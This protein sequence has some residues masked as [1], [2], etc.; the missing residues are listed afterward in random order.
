MRVC[1]R[2][3]QR[4]WIRAAKTENFTL[5]RAP[6][7]CFTKTFWWKRARSL[8]ATVSYSRTFSRAALLRPTHRVKCR[9]PVSRQKDLDAHLFSPAVGHRNSLRNRI[10]RFRGGSV[11]RVRFSRGRRKKAA[12][13]STAAESRSNAR[14]NGP[15]S[16]RPD[17]TR[18]K[19]LSRRCGAAQ[20]AF[21]GFDRHAGSLPRLHR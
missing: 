10:G 17:R 6:A 21:P 11:P 12:L 18:R 8:S 14:R 15:S 4:T 19:H 9:S 2:I 1:L 3:F 5:S 20:V 16:Q 13:D 7:P